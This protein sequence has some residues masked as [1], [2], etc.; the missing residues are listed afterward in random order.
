MVFQFYA[1]LT[2]GSEVL[3]RY[4]EKA[5]L[6]ITVS[7][8]DKGHLCDIIPCNLSDSCLFGKSHGVITR[9]SNI[10]S[11]YR[12]TFKPHIANS[13]LTLTHGVSSVIRTHVE[14]SL[15]ILRVLC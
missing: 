1:H 15:L 2:L 8:S 5:D 9:K 3:L 4:V 11:H 10:H 12:I 14:S 7:Q 13:L 6:R